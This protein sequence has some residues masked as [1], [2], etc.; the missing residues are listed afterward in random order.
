MVRPYSRPPSLTSAGVVKTHKLN[1]S[2]SECLI[3]N[4]SRT[5][6][7]CSWIASPRVLREWTNH[8]W[9]GNSGGTEE[10]TMSCGPG[11]FRLKSSDRKYEPEEGAWAA[12]APSLTAQTSSPH[13]R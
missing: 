12:A 11:F 3:A 1:F 8:F 13:D 9:T 7:T 6:C 5:D 2:P 10:I 4:A